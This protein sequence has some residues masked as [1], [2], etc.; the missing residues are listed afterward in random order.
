MFQK[1]IITELKHK[2]L[3]YTFKLEVW[4]TNSTY[5]NY[6]V[7]SQDIKVLFKIIDEITREEDYENMVSQYVV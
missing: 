2:P 6:L 5:P 7:Y 4:Y 1:A 3:K